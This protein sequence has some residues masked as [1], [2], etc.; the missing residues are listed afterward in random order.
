MGVRHILALFLAAACQPSTTNLTGFGSTPDITTTSLGSTSEGSSTSSGS[1]TTTTGVDSGSGSSSVDMTTEPARDF[2]VMP[3]FGD[4]APVGCKG[5]IDFLFVI[6]RD[7]DM[8]YRQAQLALALPQFVAAIESKFA[9]FDYHIMVVDGDGPLPGTGWGSDTCNDVCPNLACKIGEPCC[10]SDNK[11]FEGLPCCDDPNYPCDKLELVSECDHA[12]GAGT[13]FPAGTFTADKPCPIDDGRRYLVKGQTNLFE[14]FECIALVGNDGWFA[15]GHALM[16]AMQQPINDPGGCNAGFLRG[17]ALLMVTLI[18]N[19]F[20][21]DLNPGPSESLPFEW[22]EA[23]IEAKHGDDR[24]IVMFND[25]YG[26]EGVC[27]PKDRLC[28]VTE[29]FPYH[30]QGNI[31]AADYGPAFV[32][33]ASLVETACAAY[34]PPG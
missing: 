21:V 31:D 1:G 12:W 22:A 10:P 13:V 29:M 23:A 32:E 7:T 20:D 11:N 26:H 24:S 33:A 3:D 30:Y 15:V 19:G 16:A 14:T 9:D 5:K 28:V 18:A 2:G 6:S 25:G 4:G 17:D 27:N 34:V 8:Q